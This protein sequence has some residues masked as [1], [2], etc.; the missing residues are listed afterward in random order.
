MSHQAQ[1]IRWLEQDLNRMRALHLVAEL[2]LPQ[3]WI[4]AGFVRNLVWDALHSKPG[5]TPLNDIDVVYFDASEPCANAY[6]TYENKLKEQMPE[7]NWQVRNQARMHQRNN[8]PAYLDVFNAMSYWPE[9]ETA[10]AVRLNPHK[11][12]E[13]EAVFGFESLFALRV[14]HNP[15]RSKAV[16]LERVNSKTWLNQW[17]KLTV[18]D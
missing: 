8:D 6:L 18:S 1:L 17:P 16:F 11:Q 4:A 5:S 2:N 7:F 15:K 9:K 10:V 13:C 14:S 12:I 3:A